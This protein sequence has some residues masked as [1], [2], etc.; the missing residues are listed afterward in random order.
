MD[1]AVRRLQA[2]SNPH[3][4]R[5]FEARFSSGA[6]CDL[7]QKV[8]THLTLVRAQLDLDNTAE[9]LMHYLKLE[10]SDRHLAEELLADYDGQYGYRPLYAWRDEQEPVN[11]YLILE[12]PEPRL[13]GGRRFRILY[14]PVADM[15][16][17]DPLSVIFL[18]EAFLIQV[19]KKQALYVMP[20]VYKRSTP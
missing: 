17:L 13:L 3:L 2:V 16:Q 14:G 10:E 20:R 1:M 9:S 5:R 8:D 18:G 12:N 6:D 11:A 4:R 15:K 7:Q 19:S